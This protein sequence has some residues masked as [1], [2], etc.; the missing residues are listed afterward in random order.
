MSTP[1]QWRQGDEQL[2]HETAE[3]R[4]Q[5]QYNGDREMNDKDTRQQITDVNTNTME[6][7]R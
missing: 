7:G 4:C 5:H 2:R 6:T 3:N 1:I